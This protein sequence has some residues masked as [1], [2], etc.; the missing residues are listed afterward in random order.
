MCSRDNDRRMFVLVYAEMMGSVFLTH[1]VN[2]EG[3]L[4]LC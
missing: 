3:Y 2:C 4:F 1:V